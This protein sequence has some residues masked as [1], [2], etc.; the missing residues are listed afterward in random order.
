MELKQLEIQ[1]KGNGDRNLI[2]SLKFNCYFI[3]MLILGFSER[4]IVAVER[5]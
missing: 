4:L 3:L 5:V 2:D 1:N